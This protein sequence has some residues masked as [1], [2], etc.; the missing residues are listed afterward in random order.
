MAIHHFKI[1]VEQ[2]S[3]VEKEVKDVNVAKTQDKVLVQLMKQIHFNFNQRSFLHSQ[4]T[5]SPV[6]H[7]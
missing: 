6:L 3:W 4:Y 5:S 7:Q 2:K 1:S